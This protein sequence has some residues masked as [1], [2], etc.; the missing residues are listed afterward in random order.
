MDMNNLMQQAKE[1]QEK[2][3]KI[4]Q[5]LASKKV[6]G[7]AGGG[8]VTSTVNGQGEL[9]SIEIEKEVISVEEKELLQD[10]IV[11]AINDGLRKA[12]ELGKQDMSQL[13][14]GF[15]IPGLSDIL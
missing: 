15:K 1:M 14:G 3:A 13:T 6:T 12:K 9:L 5:E 8:M 2:M 4:Q 7:S 11:A 10:L